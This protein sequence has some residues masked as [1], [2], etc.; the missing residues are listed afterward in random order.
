MKKASNPRPLLI[1][2]FL[3]RKLFDD[4]VCV[5]A[6]CNDHKLATKGFDLG[7]CILCPCIR[8]DGN[9]FVSISK[10]RNIELSDNVVLVSGSKACNDEGVV[11]FS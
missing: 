8:K 9:Y 3:L 5:V 10:G 7:L 6:C 1:P 11:V 4:G 2:C